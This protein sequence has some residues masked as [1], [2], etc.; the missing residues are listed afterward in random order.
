MCIILEREKMCIILDLYDR[1]I[2]SSITEKE[3]TSDLVSS[4]WKK[5]LQSQPKILGKLI[6][7]SDQASQ[8]TSHT[9]TSYCESVGVI[10]SM[11][12]AGYI[13]FL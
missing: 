12:E 3:T 7:H 13:I 8:Y 10:Q 1:S 4:I 11:S 2:E 5:A 6:L 9:Y